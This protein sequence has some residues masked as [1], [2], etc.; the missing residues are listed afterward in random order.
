MLLE[1]G[2]G[3]S[4]N[5]IVNATCRVRGVGHRVKL[6]DMTKTGCRA[7]PSV[8]GAAPGDHVILQLTNL[9]VLPATIL[10]VRGWRTGLSF[11]NPLHGA[12]LCEFARRQ[13]FDA[14]EN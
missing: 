14:G 10:W 5:C 11:S 13:S 1:N 12:M 2:G 4:V 8:L 6:L 7:E 3:K 9:L